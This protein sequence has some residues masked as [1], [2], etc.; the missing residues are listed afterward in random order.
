MENRVVGAKK[1][2]STEA[3][4]LVSTHFLQVSFWRGN[5][6]ILQTRVGVGPHAESRR[7]GPRRQN[8]GQLNG[9]PQII[10]L[11]N[12]LGSST[13]LRKSSPCAP[14]TVFPAAGSRILSLSQTHALHHHRSERKEKSAH[15]R[16][17]G[18]NEDRSQVK[19]YGHTMAGKPGAPEL[20]VSHKPASSLPLD[21]HV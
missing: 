19:G 18:V 20:R 7:R 3:A 4:A 1:L 17:D 15:D 10:S 6:S 12:T 16:D 14:V 5:K 11:F 13:A 21:I 8:L 2:N 9:A